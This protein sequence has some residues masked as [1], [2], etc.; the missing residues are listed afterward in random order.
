M[1]GPTYKT[2]GF[3]FAFPRGSP[4]VSYMSRAILNVTQDK[5]KMDS[6]EEEKYFRSL[7]MYSFGGL[8]I[9]AAVVSMFSLLM[10]MYSFLCS[11]WPTLR[12][13]IHSENSF[14]SKM[15][16]LAKHFDKKDLTSHPFTRRTSRV[17]AMDTPDETAIGGLHDAN[18]MQNSAV[19]NNIDVNENE[20][21]GGNLLSMHLIHLSMYLTCHH[22][23]PIS[24]LNP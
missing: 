14:R 22:R 3:G 4:L 21:N 1:V 18:D 19:E 12:T 5:F 20:S 8:F 16:E 15:V 9:I 13:T 23:L 6:I 17:H 11:Q 2:A 7:H 10:Y 24:I